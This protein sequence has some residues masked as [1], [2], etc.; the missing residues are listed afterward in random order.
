MSKYIFAPANEHQETVLVLKNCIEFIGSYQ[1]GSGSCYARGKR[2]LRNKVDCSGTSIKF[3]FKTFP[4]VINHDFDNYGLFVYRFD[5]K[6]CKSILLTI[7]K[8]IDEIATEE[9]KRN[10]FNPISSPLPYID[11]LFF[12]QKNRLIWVKNHN[13]KNQ[14]DVASHLIQELKTITSILN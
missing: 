2:F 7:I 10:L 11:A 9:E 8:C 6:K 4:K 5:K 14:Q 13:Y 12:K 3:L 1:K